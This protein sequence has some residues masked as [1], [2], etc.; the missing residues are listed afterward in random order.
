MEPTVL[1]AGSWG[2]ALAIQ[3]CRAGHSVLLW[4]RDALHVREMEKTREN[5]K[6]LVGFPLPSSLT[7]TSDLA[8]AVRSATDLL[9]CA[10]PSHGVRETMEAARAHLQPQAIVCS[11]AKGIEEHFGFE[12]TIV[13]RT[14][15]EMARIIAANPLLKKGTDEKSLHV[16]FLDRAPGAGAVALLGIA[17]IGSVRRRRA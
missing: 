4:D 11:A 12:T 15:P 6:Y 13:V 5:R 17:G 16:G 8:A 14:A 2:T 10:V 9:V 3:L 1:G 7:P